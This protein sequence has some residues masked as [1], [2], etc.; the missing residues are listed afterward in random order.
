[1]IAL[2]LRLYPARWR[3]RYGDEFAALLAER[4]LGPFDVA[5]VLLGALDAQLH[6]RGLGSW[7][8]HRRGFPMSLRLGGLAAIVGGAFWLSGFLWTVIDPADED[9]GFAFAL[10]GSIALLI[11][12]AGLSAFQARSHPVLVWA[13][14]VLPA[15][16]GAVMTFGLS[17]MAVFPDQRV[18]GDVSGWAFFMVGMVGM[19]AGSILFAVATYRTGALPRSGALL[20]GVGSALALVSFVGGST[21]GGSAAPI[22][23]A[24]FLAF[25]VGWIVMGLQ[26]V[27]LD[28]PVMVTG[29][30]AA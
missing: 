16:G 6:L 28:R 22:F 24:G 17:M 10:V 26:A 23:V 3:T 20:L 11:G 27:R 30:G 4:P 8:E 21:I 9:P 25:P 14:F 12:L 5:D 2:L 13:A 1:M 15:I 19:M 18:V 29:A 7:S